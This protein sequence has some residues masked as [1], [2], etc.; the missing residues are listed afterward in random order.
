M[1][2]TME[3][4][5]FHV[6]SYHETKSYNQVQTKFRAL[7]PERLPPPPNKTLNMNKERSRRRI[8]TRKQQN[9]EAVQQ[10]SKKNEERISVT[11]NGLRISP[12]SFCQ[13]TKDLR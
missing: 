8:T 9:I 7:F 1:Q 5:I 13:I 11:R 2:L 4:R 3:Q 10:A 12:S 6:K